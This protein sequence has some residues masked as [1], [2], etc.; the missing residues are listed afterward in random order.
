MA[1][2]MVLWTIALLAGIALLLAGIINAWIIEETRAG[3]LFR[4]RQQA[5]SGVAIAM[6]PGILPGDPLLHSKPKDTEEGYD[7]VIRDE[8]GLINPNYFLSRVPDRR[9]LLKRLF[10]SWGLDMNQSDAAADG[11]FD[12]QSPVPFRSLH[13]AKKAEYHAAGLAGMPPG[14]PFVSPEEMSLVIG[15][16]PVL[17]ARPDYRSFFTTHFNGPVNVLRAPKGVLTDFLGLTPLQADAWI[18]LRAGKDC[19]EGTADDVKPE[20]LSNAVTLIGVSGPLRNLILESCGIKGGVR[21]IESTGFCNR[22]RHR[23]TVICAEAPSENPQAAAAVLGWSE[24]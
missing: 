7:V 16:D 20:D 14:A 8:S 2:P 19:M 23:I 1:L 22:V 5:L 17:K 6:N 11:L 15:F 13:G 4:A 18:T 9:D 10:A 21:R 12:W 24:Q 3:K